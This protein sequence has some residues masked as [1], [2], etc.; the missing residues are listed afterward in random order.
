[1][2]PTDPALILEHENKSPFLYL[3]SCRPASDKATLLQKKITHI[4][5]ITEEINNFFEKD[6]KFTYLRFHLEDSS[7]TD[8]KSVFDKAHKFIQEVEKSKNGAVLVHCA[9]GIS[10]S[11]TIVLSYLMKFHKMPFSKAWVF[12]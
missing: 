12:G 10:R 2:T 3:G 9:A 5:N 11:A 7:D 4:L 1:M 8:I 6:N